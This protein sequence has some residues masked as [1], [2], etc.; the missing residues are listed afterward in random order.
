MKLRLTIAGAL[1]CLTASAQTGGVF[2]A[3]VPAPGALSD[4]VLDEARQRLYL[5]NN[6]NDRV[7][8]FSIPDQRFLTPMSVQQQPVSAAMSPDG[9]FLYVTNF[10]SSSLSV[11]DLGLGGQ[12]NAVNLP[13]PPEGVAVGFDGRVLISTLGSGNV[14]GVPQNVLLLF[15]ANQTGVAQLTSLSFPPPAPQDP[16]LPGFTAAR[17]FQTFRSRLQATPDGRFI[18]GANAPTGNSTS[19]FVYEVASGTVLRSRL[20]PNLSTVFSISPDGSRFMAGL[21]LF[22]TATLN[23][24]AATSVNNAPFQ[25][26][27]GFIVNLNQNVG[28][29]VFSPDGSTL[30]S[31]FNLAPPNPPT[32]PR[33]NSSTLL[34]SNPRNLGI[35]L[36][37]RLPENILGKMVS[38]SDGATVFAL[39]ETGVLMLPVGKLYDFPILM[40]ETTAVRLS[41]NPCDRGLVTADV[42]ILNAGKGK[43]TFTFQQPAGANPNLLAQAA[44]G[45]APSSIRMMLN[46]RF[47]GTRFPGTQ[48]FALTLQS[49]EAINIPPVI[50]VYQNFQA[51]GQV[52]ETV[53]L[54]V[55]TAGAEGLV[56]MQVDNRRGRL[57]I[58]N[59]GMNRVEVYDFR[60]KK[61]LPPIEAGQLPRAMAMTSDG[62]LLY[63]AN[64][65]GEWISIVDLNLRQ[66]V[67]KVD[68]PPTPFN[69]N[70]APVG[71]RSMAM[72]IF[73][74]QFVATD[75]TVWSVRANAA[76]PR[77]PSTVL[78]PAPPSLARVTAPA[79]MVSTP[80][81]EG[82]ILLDNNGNAYRYDSLSDTWVNSQSVM[83]APINSYYGPLA[84]GPGGQYY[85]ANR[86]I[87]N[88]TLVPI[89]GITSGVGAGGVAGGGAGAATAASRHQAATAPVS[90]TTYARFTVPPQA[91]AG[92][93]PSGDQRPLI[94]LVDIATGASLVTVAAPEGPAQA[95]FGNARSNIAPRAMAIDGAGSNAFLVSTS[96]LSV[97]SL[98]QPGPADAPVINNGGIVNGA[99]FNRTVSPG[100]LIS[101]FGRNL[102]DKSSASDLP[103]P[104]LLG[105]T[106]VTFNDVTL[107]L[108]STSPTQINAQLPPDALPGAT[109]VMVHS[110]VTGLQSDPTLVNV[111][112]S[113]PGVFAIDGNVAA[114]FH[115]ADMRLVTRANPA[116][117]GEVLV[118]FGTG[119]PPADGQQLEPGAPAPANPLITT[120]TPQVF[121]GNPDQPGT[122]MRIEWSGF[123]PGF[124][125]LNQIN[126]RV[127]TDAATGDNLPVVVRTGDAE[128]PRSGPLAPVTSIR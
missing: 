11:I 76:I 67:G 114:L 79:G 84:A 74:P 65:G 82:V 57:Y 78:N 88:S 40:P 29:S 70:A 56:D 51:G 122:Q 89:G 16:R 93:T 21:R 109:A 128:S 17:P 22:E 38:T 35:N 124:I 69:S 127:P 60:N 41:I 48:T 7:E 103:L 126:L 23:V 99:T 104:Q 6:A 33:P 14:A 92:A 45:V 59:S 34:V 125:G 20:T 107:P 49:V 55:S 9:Q 52:G 43:L 108:L 63:V 77:S 31:A 5:V 1:V 86:A 112:R 106:C 18:I 111:S 2:G 96:G 26:P 53:P 42:K 87:L 72:G 80:G 81:N 62:S 100:A 64:S 71:P 110:V 83:T 91:N 98:R 47:T 66:Q 121:I 39:S 117:R 115:S 15:D 25:L 27:A 58:A 97:V 30:Y 46:P 28:G 3:R 68:F 90:A 105:G 113:A 24:L 4:M 44:S 32:Q 8:V 102:G 94:E 19:V 37:I 85:L 119:L 118:L 95:V 120:A 50:R 54:E 61:M 123:T 10:A 75:G 13:A 73:G 116:L 12:L 36:G 101:I